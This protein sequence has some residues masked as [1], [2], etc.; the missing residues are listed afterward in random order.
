METK[1]VCEKC[2]KSATVFHEVNALIAE[3]FSFIIKNHNLVSPECKLE[4]LKIRIHL[5]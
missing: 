3:V 4:N 2:G 5:K 1:W